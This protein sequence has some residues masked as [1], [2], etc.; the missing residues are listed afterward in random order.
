VDVGRQTFG[1][2]DITEIRVEQCTGL[3]IL[4][5]KELY[6]NCP[7][8]LNTRMLLGRGAQESWTFTA[9]VGCS[10]CCVVVLGGHGGCVEI[11]MFITIGLSLSSKM[12][13]LSCVGCGMHADKEIK[14][15]S[16]LW[17][18]SNHY[19]IVLPSF[20]YVLLSD[21]IVAT[22]TATAACLFHSTSLSKIKSLPV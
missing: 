16:H 17:H 7:N 8:I 2:N 20:S 9:L 6:N 14:W 19:R 1:H 5:G 21:R 12:S 4:E 3:S 18:V 11:R 15:K 22:P 13:G 10:T